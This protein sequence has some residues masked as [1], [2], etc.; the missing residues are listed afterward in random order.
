[1]NAGPAPVLEVRGL[2]L[3]FDTATVPRRVLNNVSFQIRAG[4]IFGLAGESGSGKS[5]LAYSILN[6]LS[7]NG[8]ITAGQINFKGRD[9][10]QLDEPALRNIR[11]NRIAMVY[12]DPRS[13]LNPSM[14]V[15]EQIAE[16]LE[17]HSGAT[18]SERWARALAL[19]ELVNIGDPPAVAR[20]YPHQ[21][22]GGM[23]Q[24]IVIAMALACDPE[25][26][27]MDEP[28]TGLDV[29]TQARIIDLIAEL[30]AKVKAA[31]LFIAH[32]LG[33]VAEIS[34]QV[35]ILY[36]GEL[37]EVASCDALFRHPAHPYTQ[38]LLGAIP[39]IARAR[40]PT[41]I[42]GNLPDLT[43][44]GSG[45]IFSPRCHFVERACEARIPDMVAVGADQLVKCRRWQEVIGQ[46]WRAFPLEEKPRTA[47]RA[48]SDEKVVTVE[49]L[50]KHY[51]RRSV[52]GRWFGRQDQSVKAVDDV[53]L[54]VRRGE[55]LAVVGESGSGK[56][57]LGHCIIGLQVPTE[58]EVTYTSWKTSNGSTPAD[59]AE[60]RRV[61]QMVF[62]HPDLSLNPKKTVQS[63]LKRPLTVHGVPRSERDKRVET[64]LREVRLESYYRTRYPSQLS[65][66]E[67]QRIAIARAFALEPEFVL[68]DEPVSSL[69]VSVQAAIMNLLGQLKVEIG[70]AYLFISHDLAVVRSF[71][72]RVAVMYLGRFCE[73]GPVDAVFGP[74]YHPYTRALLSAVPTPDP[75]KQRNIVR[76]EGAIPSPRNPPSGCRFH[77]RCPNK[78]G[79]VCED[80]E[81]PLQQ[82]GDGHWI[83]CHIPLAELAGQP[84]VLASPPSRQEA[85]VKDRSH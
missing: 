11:G 28:T 22:S 51:D 58:G 64:L 41:P 38:G 23:Q 37:V 19:L 6:Y 83:A 80:S 56:T 9:L 18:R 12:Q 57:T 55:V 66:G 75:H 10:L 13:A 24:R 45:C 20:R 15:G 36:A 69:D 53:S 35:G 43:R 25:L 5:S 40:R 71:A 82:A 81:P 46:D 34:D 31:F 74:P 47:E 4:E 1:M 52:F 70:C 59:E 8:R 2:A 54:N 3:E 27:I 72:N 62:Q 48:V 63:I 77:T 16:V 14:R 49:R 61:T 33:L 32:D 68:L 76:L 67:K 26:L 65:G 78:I 29:T 42:A 85:A 7:P 17:L 60:L 39:N 73:V 21:L 79:R 44:R 84:P 30:K 50:R